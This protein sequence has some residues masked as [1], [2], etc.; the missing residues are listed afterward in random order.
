MPTA[1]Q[2]ADPPI[3]IESERLLIVEGEDEV[4]FFSAFHNHLRLSEVQ[5]L[6][7]GGKDRLAASLGALVRT[8]G[9]RNVQN[10]AVVRDAN[11]NP[12]GAFQSVC[13]ALTANGL[14]APPTPLVPAGTSPRVMV[15]ILPGNGATGMLENLCLQSVAND[16]VMPCVDAYFRCVKESGHT[17]PRKIA[18]A[19]VRVFLASRPK[20]DLPVG[21]AAGAGYWPWE[22]PAFNDLRTVANHLSS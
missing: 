3:A 12:N 20:P 22:N 16:P 18:K 9:F 4:R 7:I 10:L 17:P 8:R 5:I 11:G 19:R 2:P 14:P 1:N 13:S 21:I 15:A 6:G